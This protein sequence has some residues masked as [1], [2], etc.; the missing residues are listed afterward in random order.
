[1]I[2]W[3]SFF[4]QHAKF[5]LKL[6]GEALSRFRA[7]LKPLIASPADLRFLDHFAAAATVDNASDRD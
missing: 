6:P 4:L 3:Q 1:M 2:M 5:V 7:C